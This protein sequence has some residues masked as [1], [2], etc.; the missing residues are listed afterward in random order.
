[1]D[2]VVGRQEAADRRKTFPY[3]SEYHGEDVGA[4]AFVEGR[5]VAE[6][7]FGLYLL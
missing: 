4:M 1:M 3:R 2:C 6:V 7:E 5:N